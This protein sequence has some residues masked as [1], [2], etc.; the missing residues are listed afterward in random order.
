MDN[1]ILELDFTDKTPAG[2]GLGYLSPGQHQATIL[3]FR[4]YAESNRLYCYMLTEGI[5]HRESFSLSDKGIG[6][7]MGLLVSAGMAADKLTGKQK[8]PFHKFVGRSVYFSYTPPTLGANGQPVE[9]SYPSYRFYPEA[10]YN[11]MVAAANAAIENIEIEA[12]TNGSNGQ[13]ISTAP[14]AA[15]DANFDFL[16]EGPQS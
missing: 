10:Q 4:H 1:L 14:A 2:G 7:V 15:A 5:R 16:I 3:E 8:I 9:N 13:A 11:S 12:P 6:F